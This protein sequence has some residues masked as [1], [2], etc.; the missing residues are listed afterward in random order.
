MR[1]IPAL[2]VPLRMIRTEYFILLALPVVAVPNVMILIERNWRNLLRLW[3]CPEVSVLR[4]DLLHLLGIGLLRLGPGISLCLLLA[5]CRNRRTRICHCPRWMFHTLLPLLNLLLFA[6]H[7][8][9]RR[10]TGNIRFCRG[11]ICRF[12]ALPSLPAFF[13]TCFIPR[14]TGRFSGGIRFSSVRRFVA[15]VSFS[16]LFGAGLVASTAFIRNAAL[17]YRSSLFRW[18][19]LVFSRVHAGLCFGGPRFLRGMLAL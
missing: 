5:C 8:H 6:V 16:A 17:L 3:L 1:S 12:P 13:G 7:R 4:F 18:L 15:H 2:I 10:M 14:F 19:L 9:F 11:S